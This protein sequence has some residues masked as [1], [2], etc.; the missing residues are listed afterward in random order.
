MEWTEPILI[1][2]GQFGK[3]LSEFPGNGPLWLKGWSDEMTAIFMGDGGRLVHEEIVDADWVDYNGHMNVAYYVLVFDHAT[4]AMLELLD[5]GADYRERTDSSD[6]VIESHVSYLSEVVK[7]D[8]LQVTSLLLGFDDKRL[9]LFHHMYHRQSEQLCATIELML[10]HVDM[11]SRR[12]AKFP[13]HVKENLRTFTENQ[14]P[15]ELPSQCGAV[16]GIR[17]R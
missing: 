11:K 7:E 2:E 8:P 12:S 4:D 15:F 17:Q 16:I 14:Q 5:M 9:H 1:I 3:G 6:F 10:V 13:G